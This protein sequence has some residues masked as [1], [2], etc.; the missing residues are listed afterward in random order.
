MFEDVENN[1]EETVENNVENNVEETVENNV[2]ETMNTT[3]TNPPRKIT[4][5]STRGKN[6]TILESD[7]VTWGDLIEELAG[8]YPLDSMQAIESAS[9]VHY[10]HPEAVLPETAFNLFLT[11]SA[12]K[13]G[14]DITIEEKKST[15]KFLTVYA[16]ELKE[17]IA[18][19]EIKAAEDTVLGDLEAQ[20]RRLCLAN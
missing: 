2:E 13:S 9:K 16:E 8:E 11:P 5:Y 17:E 18:K 19:D 6:C 12:P 15:L 14:V 10:S 7:A 1:V 4:V 3:A 20:A